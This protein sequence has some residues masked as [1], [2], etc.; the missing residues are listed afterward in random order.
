MFTGDND[1]TADEGGP[2][3]GHPRAWE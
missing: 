1:E 3:I 2:P